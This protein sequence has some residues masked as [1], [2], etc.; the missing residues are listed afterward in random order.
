[1]W[2]QCGKT[3]LVERMQSVANGLIG[4]AQVVRNRRGRLA[5]STGEEDLAAA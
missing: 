2:L 1:L 3:A 5:L 4:T